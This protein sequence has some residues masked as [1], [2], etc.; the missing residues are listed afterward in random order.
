MGNTPV[1]ELVG[2]VVEIGQPV[3]MILFASELLKSFCEM[4]GVNLPAWT[5]VNLWPVGWKVV[6]VCVAV[7]GLVSVA[8]G[9]WQTVR[10]SQ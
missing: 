10:D 1:K 7:W 8:V 5:N 6:I 9:T 3:G 2:A 4:A